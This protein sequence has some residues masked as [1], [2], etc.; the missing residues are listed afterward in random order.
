MTVFGG[1]AGTVSLLGRGGSRLART[2]LFSAFVLVA[3]ALPARA[4]GEGGATVVTGRAE[5][6][7]RP[8]TGDL[9]SLGGDLVVTGRVEGDLI[10]WGGRVRL[11]PTAA[12]DGSVLLVGTTWEA[13]EGSRV[14]G[15][16]LYWA[17]L[18]EVAG[19]ILDGGLPA[20]A[21]SMKRWSWGLRLGTLAAWL[22]AA[23]LLSLA[24]R[25]AVEECAEALRQGWLR[26]FAA[27]VSLL[28]AAV[29]V[30]WGVLVLCPPRFGLPILLFVGASALVAKIFGLVTVFVAVGRW[31]S[32]RLG[33]KIPP[34]LPMAATAGLLLLGAGRFVPVAGNLVWVAASLVGMGIAA[35]RLVGRR[36]EPVDLP[37][38]PI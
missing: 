16:V 26:A 15:R 21:E 30:A 8:L 27:G 35:G 7:D 38:E 4:S 12:V 25:T 18:E 24:A 10:A 17:D 32:R 23:L 33:R 20:D 22:L 1:P 31:I 3:P 37:V 19:G 2:F 6:I 28:L 13:Q 29:L 14:G 9:V 36:R 5:R 11:E 34:A